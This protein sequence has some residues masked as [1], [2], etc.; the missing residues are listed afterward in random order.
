MAHPDRPLARPASGALA[1]GGVLGAVAL[2][3]VLSLALGGGGREAPS[4]GEFAL[5]VPQAF[6]AGLLSFLSPCTLPLLPAYFA[7]RVQASGQ[8][9]APLTVAFFLG[10]ATTLTLLG[11]SATALSQ[12]LFQHLRQLTAIGGLVIVAFGVLSLLGKGFTG[13]QLQRRPAATLAGSYIYGATFALGWSACIGPILGAILTL[14]AASGSSVVQG[15][16]LGVF[17][18]LTVALGPKGIAP[19]IYFQF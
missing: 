18:A 4:A 6:L 14:L 9:A 8:R 13:P 7:Y 19:F 1:L 10:L 17:F 15:A 16:A 3:V 5:L 12:V 11:A 2:L